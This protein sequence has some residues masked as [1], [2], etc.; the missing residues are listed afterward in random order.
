M[1]LESESDF[2]WLLFWNIFFFQLAK[3]QSSWMKR[4]QQQSWSKSWHIEIKR[5][6]ASKKRNTFRSTME[7]T[8]ANLISHERQR[9][10]TKLSN[11]LEK[12]Q[13]STAMFAYSLRVFISRQ[14]KMYILIVFIVFFV[15]LFPRICSN[16]FAIIAEFRINHWTVCRG[17]HPKIKWFNK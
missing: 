10:T 6:C 3:R 7:N 5:R 8:A 16:R 11:S 1:K 4:K 13:R 9:P 14:S 12:T 15:G 17:K 2:S